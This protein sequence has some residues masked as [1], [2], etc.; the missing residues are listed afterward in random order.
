MIHIYTGDGPGKTTAA[1]GLALRSLGH[2]KRVA[3]VQFLK[4]RPSGEINS[5]ARFADCQVRRFG[6]EEFIFNR[7]PDPEDIR[8]A[9]AALAAAEEILR[10]RS[11]DLLILDE[12]NVAL[13]LG[14]VP[15]ERVEELVSGCPAEIELVL[16]G[17]NCPA[18]LLA[19]AD[20]ASEIREIRHPFPSGGPPR[21]GI[22]F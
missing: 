2:G 17:R 15:L 3:L 21:E 18:A 4:K 6:K 14:L 12:I 22:E 11:I 16:T 19:R 8:E 7:S 9:R 5:L 1:L 13:D 20:Y 10:E